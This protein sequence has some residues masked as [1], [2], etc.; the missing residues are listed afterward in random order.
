M[1]FKV[2]RFVMGPILFVGGLLTLIPLSVVLYYHEPLINGI[3]FLI[4][5][6]IMLLFGS[7]CYYL[8][9]DDNIPI[10]NREG[11]VIVA[12][13]WIILSFFGA[14]PFIIS[15]EVPSFI[16]AF[17]ETVSGYTT[18]GA[19]ILADVEALSHSMLFWRSFLHL[20]GGMGILVFVLALI[21]RARRGAS[22]VM[23]SEV[24]G[25]TFDQITP[26]ITTMARSLYLIY[27]AFFTIFL[28]SLRLSGMP[29]FDAMV[30]A[31]GTAGTGGFAIKATG[32]ASYPVLS[33]YLL[34]IGMII[35]G[36]N[37]NLYFYFIVQK[38]KDA[39]KSEELWDYLGIIGIATLLITINILPNVKSLEYSFRQAFFTVASIIT[40]TGFSISDF[41]QWPNFSKFILVLLM[42]IGGSAGST[43]G[44]LKVSRVVLLLK[45]SVNS[46]LS[47]LKPNRVNHLRYEYAPVNH[48]MI[49]SV[50]NYFIL[51]VA[52]FL[53]LLLIISA[54]TPD[55][56]TAISAV[57][58]TYNNVG[59]GLAEVGPTSSFVELNDF[60]KVVLSFAMLLGR[61]EIF[62][63][64]LLFSK[65]TWRRA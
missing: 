6:L 11:I 14:L 57:A 50:K 17:F 26:R 5:A 37:F 18:T 59:P 9:R 38:K 25:P 2:I 64:L 54:S 15:G 16:D 10:Y 53:V 48:D 12:L 49:S 42:F 29:W 13:A 3:A 24:P 58:T 32:S 4:P 52:I 65:S 63:M 41:N 43:A 47:I 35:F 27:F 1:N 33:Q 31:F 46:V 39:M 45:D 19:S 8:E 7:F 61:L 20:I 51:Y 56:E 62:P 40:T 36:V 34:T 55:F 60:S 30:H 44:G 23:R 21:P 22:R 28:I